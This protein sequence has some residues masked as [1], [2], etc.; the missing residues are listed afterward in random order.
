MQYHIENSLGESQKIIVLKESQKE[1]RLG[2]SQK[3]IVSLTR[4]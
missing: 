4:E 2:E 1:S 3:I